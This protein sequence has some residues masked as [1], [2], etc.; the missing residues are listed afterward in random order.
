MLLACISDKEDELSRMQGERDAVKTAL[1]EATA[2]PGKGSFARDL[3]PGQLATMKKECGVREDRASVPP[4]PKPTSGEG[5]VKAWEDLSIRHM[6]AVLKGRGEG[7]AI[8]NVAVALDRCGYLEKLT[9]ATRFLPASSTSRNR[10][11]PM[12][13]PRSRRDGVPGTLSMSGIGWS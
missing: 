10:S 12:L 4:R 13:L 1:T 7:D 3:A 11:R 6:A 9:G 8:N 2:G 5:A